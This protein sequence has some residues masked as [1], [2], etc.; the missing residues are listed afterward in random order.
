MKLRRRPS[1]ILICAAAV[2]FLGSVVVRTSAQTTTG[3]G[4]DD[5]PID[6][7]NGSI[8]QEGESDYSDHPTYA[9]GTALP[10]LTDGHKSRMQNGIP[11]HC[12]CDEGWTGLRCHRPY[13]KCDEN[14]HYCYHGGQCIDFGQ[15]Q[16][17]SN[18]Q[19]FCDCNA[20]SYAGN[21]MYGKF[22]ELPAASA[23]PNDDTNFCLNGG[24]CLE[25]GTCDCD[26]D[27]FEGPHC[28]F[29]KD[30]VPDC[31]LECGPG[32]CVLGLKDVEA[33]RYS[34]FWKNQQDSDSYMYCE[35]P[36]GR[37]GPE[38]AMEGEVC[39]DDHCFNGASCIETLSV[40]GVTTEYKCDCTTAHTDD[41]SFAGKYC[42]SAS[43][44]F[45]P[46]SPSNQH[47]GKLFCTNGGTCRA[48]SDL[49]LGCD[50][51]GTGFHGPMCQYADGEDAEECTL[52]CQNGG[53]CRVGFKDVSFAKQRGKEMEDYYDQTHDGSFQHCV[54]DSAHFGI[55]CQHEL[56]MCADGS[57]FCLHGSKCVSKDD[58]AHECDCDDAGV[59]GS[60]A[61]AG[62]YCQYS[63]TDV[64][65]IGA[66]SK[67]L[68]DATSRNKDLAFC[69]NNGTCKKQIYAGEP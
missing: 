47:N 65:Y 29:E 59:D 6:C 24:T 36:D 2:V 12:A 67:G 32:T 56:Q 37:F 4:N 25:N 54:C 48:E 62:K 14:G 52:D 57:H 10:F 8:C 15:G 49:H 3:G 9:D 33:A 45:C 18:D 42:Q 30:Q 64:C 34:Q 27:K 38:C 22:C 21:Q 46:T 43:T 58:G 40:D 17:I 35:C 66:D 44:T 31:D 1:N 68:E 51:E 28:E 55:Q 7:T 11:K 61:F 53:K 19:V 16:E 63:S 20:A 26:A 13:V 23:C 5:C 50:C 60:E 69:V 39:G 41:T